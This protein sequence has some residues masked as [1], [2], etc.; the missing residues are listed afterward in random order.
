MTKPID[1]FH[2]PLQSS[3]SLAVA[4]SG[5]AGVDEAATSTRRN[6]HAIM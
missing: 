3:A 6:H 4:G 5:F 2:S 1:D